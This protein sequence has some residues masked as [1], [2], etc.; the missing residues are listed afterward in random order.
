[1]SLQG[2]EGERE[3][4]G[5]WSCGEPD[6]LL[7]VSFTFGFSSGLGLGKEM[8]HIIPA[9]FD[10]QQMQRKTVHTEEIN[11]LYLGAKIFMR[12][13]DPLILSPHANSLR[14]ES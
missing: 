11:R 7:R 9:S 13:V 10:I 4:L 12:I 5:R 2:A 8:L 1:M 14:L 6:R 3:K